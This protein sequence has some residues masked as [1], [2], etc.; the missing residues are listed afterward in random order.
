MGEA[1]FRLALCSALRT[2]GRDVSKFLLTKEGLFAGRPDERF[3]AITASQNFICNAHRTAS[4]KTNRTQSYNSVRWSIR[5]NRP[6][7]WSRRL[8]SEHMVPRHIIAHKAKVRN[9]FVEFARSIR[10]ISKYFDT[11]PLYY[12]HDT[13]GLYLSASYVRGSIHVIAIPTDCRAAGCSTHRGT[14]KTARNRAQVCFET[15]LP[16]DADI[17]R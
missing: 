16:P 1:E 10:Q 11:S 12:Q 14:W 3:M 5:S 13:C 8:T 15:G 4:S 7:F 6:I 17:A 2:S 9:S